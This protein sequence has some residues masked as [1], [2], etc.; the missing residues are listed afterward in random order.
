[1]RHDLLTRTG[2]ST[3]VKSKRRPAGA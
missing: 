2:Y 3:T 1:M